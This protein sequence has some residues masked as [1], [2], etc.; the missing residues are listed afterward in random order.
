MALHD[1]VKYVSRRCASMPNCH[2]LY[3]LAAKYD[4]DAGDVL[5]FLRSQKTPS[6]RMLRELAE[7]LDETVSNLQHILDC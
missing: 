7:E 1:L 2:N 4:W 5:A 3:E 6:K